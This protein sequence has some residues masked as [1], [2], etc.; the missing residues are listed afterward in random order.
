[1]A[2]RAEPALTTDPAVSVRR[3]PP[4]DDVAQLTIQLMGI[5]REHDWSLTTGQRPDNV[6]YAELRDAIRGHLDRAGVTISFVKR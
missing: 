6:A 1:M 2:T 4:I 5:M 3:D